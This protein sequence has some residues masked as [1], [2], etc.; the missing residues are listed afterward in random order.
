[1]QSDK[2]R[3]LRKEYAETELSRASAEDDPIALFG[4]WFDEAV[5]A[6][7]REPNAMTLASADASGSP[8][9][10]VVLLKEF[11]ERGFVFYT[12]YESRKGVE[13]A[14]NPRATLVFYWAELERQV[15]IAGSVEKVSAAESDEYFASRPHGAQLGAWAS[16]QS[17]PIATRR[18]L[19][20]AR[21]A[22][23][24]ESG[25]KPVTRPP[26][27]GG[28]R[29]IPAR[30]EFWKGRA[31]RLHDRFAFTLT[32]PGVWKVERLAP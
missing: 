13:L 24:K 4:Q 20:R 14:A 10:R 29:V 19:E 7:L 26:F 27:W 6:E 28:Y 3:R 17:R 15:R 30:V 8:N 16:A 11:D 23:E 25:G 9:A 1:M 32:A 2:I 21:D 22:R 31:D 18:D 5:R 12:N